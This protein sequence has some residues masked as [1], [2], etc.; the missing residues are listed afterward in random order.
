MIARCRARPSA[1]N[2]FTLVSSRY[3]RIRRARIERER[4]RAREIASLYRALRKGHEDN[5]YEPG[6]ADFYYGEMEMRRAATPLGVER[7]VLNLYWLLSGYALRASRSLA[8]ALGCLIGASLLFVGIGFAPEASEG[9]SVIEA[10][11]YSARTGVG[12]MRD[13]QP[14]LTLWGDVI[15]ILVRIAVPVFLGLT[16]LSIRGRVKR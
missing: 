11:I 3:L 6:A 16:V 13:T 8:A 5:K 2:H 10:L 12:L 9:S 4:R 1:V 15:Q 14:A 7:L